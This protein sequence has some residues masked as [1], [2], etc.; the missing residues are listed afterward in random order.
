MSKKDLQNELRNLEKLAKE[1]K[2]KLEGSNA[3]LEKLSGVWAKR[4]EK[5]EITPLVDSLKSIENNRAKIKDQLKKKR[6]EGAG[7]KHDAKRLPGT[8]LLST[9]E[10]QKLAFAGKYGVTTKTLQ[11]MK[12]RKK[13]IPEELFL[14]E[15]AVNI[16]PGKKR[17][18]RYVAI[19]MIVAAI[20]KAKSKNVE[21]VIQQGE[22]STLQMEWG[23]NTIDIYKIRNDLDWCSQFH[24]DKDMRDAFMQQLDI[25]KKEIIRLAVA[26]KLMHY[27]TRA[28]C[29]YASEPFKYITIHRGQR[30]EMLHCPERKCRT[31]GAHTHWC[32]ICRKPHH[33]Q[34]PCDMEK[35][36]KEHN[37][38]MR[39]AYPEGKEKMTECPTCKFLLIK[40]E[41][42]DH[43][44][45]NLVHGGIPCRT[46]FCF[47]CGKPFTGEDGIY[48][49]QGS[50][51]YLRHLIYT[52]EGWRCRTCS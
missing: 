36:R 10:N 40:D 38:R 39:S 20:M 24:P 34:V 33:Q 26:H 31:N 23:D 15:V 9:L 52:E 6:E 1:K 45:C 43:V 47:G 17:K 50:E 29:K 41:A 19:E 46:E 25:V 28:G 44:T 16:L 4:H 35:S 11:E 51:N 21:F 18:K 7:A 48:A 49:Q 13:G 12:K 8:C 14:L 3:R 2:T 22:I 27:C 37:A 30:P 5:R 42:C 32:V